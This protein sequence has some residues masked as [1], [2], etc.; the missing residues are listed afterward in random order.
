MSSPG[1]SGSG[2]AVVYHDDEDD[3]SVSMRL[4]ALE[5][6]WRSQAR[7]LHEMRREIS[8][9]QQD[10][11]RTNTVLH[12]VQIDVARLDLWKTWLHDVWR[13]ILNSM[14]SFPWP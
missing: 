3:D 1:A 11:V 8:A 7:M 9:L 14:R 6:H 13:W 2:N 10:F 5:M 12:V 4:Q